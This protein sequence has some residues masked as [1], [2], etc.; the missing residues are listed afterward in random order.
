MTQQELPRRLIFWVLHED[1]KP[2]YD[3]LQLLSPKLQEIVIVSPERLDY[4]GESST[5]CHSRFITDRIYTGN[6]CALP[7][8]RKITLEL[9]TPWNWVYSVLET[10]H[11]LETLELHIT[12]DDLDGDV[13]PSVST[14]FEDYRVDLFEV[15]NLLREKRVNCLVIH[16]T[17]TL[18]RGAFE[19]LSFRQDFEASALRSLHIENTSERYKFIWESLPLY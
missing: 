17:V 10:A 11:V 15:G 13:S 5:M 1:P 6:N 9:S 14:L 3:L 19:P 4:T 18:R 16:V 2:L 12:V 7:S 8:I